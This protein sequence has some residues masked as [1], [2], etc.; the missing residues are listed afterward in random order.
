MKSV[1]SPNLAPVAAILSSAILT[2][3]GCSASATAHWPIE[4]PAAAVHIADVPFFAQEQYQC[5][6]AAL[7]MALDWSGDEVTPGDL[8]AAVYTPDLHGSLQASIVAAARRH[9]RVA[10]VVP[11]PEALFAELD[12]GNP[13]IVL[14]NLRFSWW[15]AW[16]YAVVVGYDDRDHTLLMHSG[17]RA[18]QRMDWRHFAATWRPEHRWGLVVLAPG[19]IPAAAS[20]RAY[21]EAVVALERADQWKAAAT[22]PRAALRRWPQS[23]A[24][25]I[26]LA[27]S[28]L[29][30]D[31]PNEAEIVL[32]TIVREHPHSAQAHNNLAHVLA[33]NDKHSEA[34][35][36][37]RLAVLLGGK[38]ARIYRR[39]LEEIEGSKGP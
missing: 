8:V 20:A 39:T 17:T 2:V 16:H 23:L 30:L 38:R 21:L 14:Q 5:G 24:A 33:L 28:E 37:A 10:Y 27:N 36:Q 11:S 35:D 4:A 3:A 7:A 29:G 18:E 31:R 34:L 25:G 32:R 6:P 1:P 22:S 19:R 9:G 12:A 26:G 15:P 13:V